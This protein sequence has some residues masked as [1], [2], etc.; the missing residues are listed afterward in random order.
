MLLFAIPLVMIV[1]GLLLEALGCEGV[2]NM[3]GGGLALL[4]FVGIGWLIAGRD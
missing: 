3:A 2:G 4:V 1:L